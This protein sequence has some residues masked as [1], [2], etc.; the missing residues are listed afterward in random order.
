MV[1]VVVV[2][3]GTGGCAARLAC[4]SLRRGRSGEADGSEPGVQAVVREGEDE[5]EHEARTAAWH[6][7]SGAKYDND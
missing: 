5:S 2:V 6:G 1:V 7:N 4:E 3:V